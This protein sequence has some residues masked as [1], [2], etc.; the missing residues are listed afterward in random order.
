V[1][2]NQIILVAF[3]VVIALWFAAPALRESQ[4]ARMLLDDCPAHGGTRSLRVDCPPR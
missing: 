1:S 2:R 3:A 4:L